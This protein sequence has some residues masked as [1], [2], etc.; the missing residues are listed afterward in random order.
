M[1]LLV[2]D[3]VIGVG[4]QFVF[5]SFSYLQE[6]PYR[7]LEQMLLNTWAAPLEWS[8]LKVSAWLAFGPWKRWPL[9]KVS[10]NPMHCVVVWCCNG[11]SIFQWWFGLHAGNRGFRRSAI[12][13]SFAH[14]SFRSNRSPRVIQVR[15]R[16][17]LGMSKANYYRCLNAAWQS[18]WELHSCATKLWVIYLRFAS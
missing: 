11:S 17:Q 18:L 2:F 6:W 5:W 7:I 13:P 12:H 9:A 4:G 10:G 14:W 15:C 3:V 16:E 1:M 8:N